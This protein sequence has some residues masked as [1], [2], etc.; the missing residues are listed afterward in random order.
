MERDLGSPLSGG[1][2]YT[3]LL[4]IPLIHPGPSC[5]GP[6]TNSLSPMLPQ[7]LSLVSSPSPPL[8]S[9]CPGLSTAV[10]TSGV[11]GAGS[12]PRRRSAPALDASSV[13]ALNLQRVSDSATLWTVAR[14]APLSMGFSRQEYWSGL[15]FPPP[16]DLP[17][18]GIEPGSP[19]LADGF[20]TV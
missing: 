5:P 3:L 4:S 16:G 2:P 18:P 1:P 7:F 10:S 9:C 6:P 13:P 8:Q 11:L 19:I 17:D 12:K 15:P 14:Q 20:F